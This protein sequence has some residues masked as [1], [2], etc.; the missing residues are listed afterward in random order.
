MKYEWHTFMFDSTN[1]STFF[2]CLCLSQVRYEHGIGIRK[3]S[4]L[5]Q[6]YRKYL[7]CNTEEWKYIYICNV[8]IHNKNIS[9][10]WWCDKIFDKMYYY[11][12]EC[13]DKRKLFKERWRNFNCNIL[14][15]KIHSDSVILSR[16]Y[17]LI[18]EGQKHIL[19]G[20]IKTLKILIP[21]P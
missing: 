6:I 2:Y 19:K 1:K 9:K 20:L 16:I 8:Y 5:G 7:V 21:H 17:L 14:N 11:C 12:L 10:E 4:L 18:M 15:D 13:L 3:I